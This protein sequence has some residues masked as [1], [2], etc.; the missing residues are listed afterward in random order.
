MLDSILLALPRYAGTDDFKDAADIQKFD[1]ILTEILNMKHQL[2]QSQ[3][4][5]QI[6]SQHQ[7]LQSENTAKELKILEEKC[8][9]L[10]V[11]LEDAKFIQ[12]AEHDKADSMTS[13]RISIEILIREIQSSLANHPF[14][15]QCA[16][17]PDLSTLPERN[18]TSQYQ[19]SFM[20]VVFDAWYSGIKTQLESI[21]RALCQTN[22]FGSNQNSGPFPTS[23]KDI[24]LIPA[25]LS[26]PEIHD[27]PC[28]ANLIPACNCK[29]SDSPD[30]KELEGRLSLMSQ[31]LQRS[32]DENHKLQSTLSTNK[33]KAEQRAECAVRNLQSK[34]D[35]FEGQIHA[36]KELNARHELRINELIS[37]VCTG[38]LLSPR[39]HSALDFEAVDCH[40]QSDEPVSSSSVFFN[41]AE[42]FHQRDTDWSRIADSSQS[43]WP[44][45]VHSIEGDS[46]TLLIQRLKTSLLAAVNECAVWK[47]LSR[48]ALYAKTYDDDA[49]QTELSQTLELTLA[50]DSAECDD[51]KQKYSKLQKYAIPAQGRL[52]NHLLFSSVLERPDKQTLAPQD[53]VA[54]LC[55][56]TAR[57]EASATSANEGTRFLCDKFL[58]NCS[59]DSPFLSMNISSKQR[60]ADQISLSII[61]AVLRRCFG[62]STEYFAVQVGLSYK[63]MASRGLAL[64][65]CANDVSSF[66][67]FFREHGVS[68]SSH[69]VCSDE[70][71]DVDCTQVLGGTLADILC[72]LKM[73]KDAMDR[74]VA[75]EKYLFFNFSGHGTQIADLDGDEEDGFDEAICPSDFDIS[76]SLTDDVLCGWLESLPVHRLF[77]VCDCCHSGTC[78]DLGEF[79]GFFASGCR[80]DE[81]AANARDDEGKT[82]GG[83]TM[84]LLN[85]LSGSDCSFDLLQRSIDA[86]CTCGK[87]FQRP[88]LQCTSSSVLRGWGA[89]KEDG[90]V[91]DVVRRLQ[92]T[93]VVRS[94]SVHQRSQE[95][96][97]GNSSGRF[98]NSKH[99]STEFNISTINVSSLHSNKVLE[100]LAASKALVQERTAHAHT[101]ASLE[102]AA[103][104]WSQLEHSPTKCRE[105]HAVDVLIEGVES[106][107]TNSASATHNN[108]HLPVVLLA[109]VE[110]P[111][112]CEAFLRRS[113]EVRH[114]QSQ[115]RQGTLKAQEP[116]EA[117]SVPS[118]FMDAQLEIG[119]TSALTETTHSKCVLPSRESPYENF[120]D[121]KMPDEHA[122]ALQYQ[123]AALQDV[124]VKVEAASSAADQAL[125]KEQAAHALTLMSLE[126][127]TMRQSQLEQDILEL[128]QLNGV[129]QLTVAVDNSDASVAEFVQGPASLQFD[130]Q[131]ARIEDLTR[132]LS[133]SRSR[134]TEF[135]KSFRDMKSSFVSAQNHFAICKQNCVDECSSLR[136]AA[137][138]LASQKVALTNELSLLKSSYLKFKDA[139]IAAHDKLAFEK[140]SIVQE[141]DRLAVK[142]IQLTNDLE[143]LRSTLAGNESQRFMFD[144]VTSPQFSLCSF[145]LVPV[146][147]SNSIEYSQ[148]SIDLSTNAQTE[149]KNQIDQAFAASQ[150]CISQLRNRVIKSEAALDHERS[151]Y[152]EAASKL[153][154][155]EFFLE[156]M[157]FQL[158]ESSA[159]ITRKVS[160]F[161]SIMQRNFELQFFSE[162]S[163]TQLENAMLQIQEL[164]AEKICLQQ[165]N[166]QLKI[167][168]FEI[169]ERFSSLEG[170]LQVCD[171]S[172][173]LIE[174]FKI[175]R[176]ILMKEL[177]DLEFSAQR[178][179]DSWQVAAAVAKNEARELNATIDRLVH[180]NQLLLLSLE[181]KVPLCHFSMFSH[182]IHC[183]FMH[184][185]TI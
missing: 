29:N 100:D 28:S 57:V 149:L 77:A 75:K 67:S 125:G 115:R 63:H 103:T 27:A 154:Q 108:P 71:V 19:E 118:T 101:L 156:N 74:S 4:D 81:F 170:M 155:A 157:K 91:P 124:A 166:S 130:A 7:R 168:L 181:N 178:Q 64:Q 180:E 50:K 173:S 153:M 177:H 66:A 11:K 73:T 78:L 33:L 137:S 14:A 45:D 159:D 87:F 179:L 44:V 17:P 37:R 88:I 182:D 98:E 93:D 56:V 12:A 40:L 6:L 47:R 53:Q 13:A 184:F 23:T 82:G 61:S 32:N 30:I 8:I 133:Q 131:V 171:R 143:E 79:E 70:I 16:T 3:N 165:D 119:A 128:R 141:R 96:E 162:E 21:Q 69:F 60:F 26:N 24:V 150:R 18:M 39:F 151:L 136:L 38:E 140:L 152:S 185:A 51:W 132:A 146:S 72:A 31:E 134:A 123:I 102:K 49:V 172:H 121:L 129:T 139:T 105:A 59:S 35:E 104:R 174:S 80:D 2:N 145:A 163:E 110:R 36:L 84:M 94:A 90:V 175:E 114:S 126:Q 116:S 167:D 48:A 138:R 99:A 86:S 112:S 122:A 147:H 85:A 25:I 97:N 89:A 148:Q 107:S 160:E 135:S 169:R 127:A 161:N 42:A 176:A 54:E 183:L 120:G 95:V 1:A 83:L 142:V 10:Q 164:I 43:T 158:R 109:D 22:Y 62:S 111:I 5:I 46:R 58:W 20:D 76:G 113:Q 9:I 106:P 68:F 41:V 15:L 144:S 117:L 65:G 34:T 52:S 55:D 92:K